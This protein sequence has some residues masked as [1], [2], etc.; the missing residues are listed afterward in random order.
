MRKRT[1]AQVDDFAICPFVVIRDSREQSPWC[2]RSLRTDAS[3]GR[4][5]LIIQVEDLGIPTGDYSIKGHHGTIAIE[6]KE[7][8]DLFHCMGSDRERFE[9]QVRR[10]NDIEH[11]YVI[12]ECDWASVWAGHP[13]SELK[14]K[15]VHRT[16]ISWTMRYPRVHWFFMPTRHVAEATAFRILE[17]FHKNLPKTQ[18]LH[19]Q[20][21]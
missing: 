13:R 17:R 10:L 12:V 11:G 16:V 20:T 21:D 4:K 15:V 14:P 3:A 7:K 18:D 19:S 6:R 8:G 2:F 1:D 5:P 9:N